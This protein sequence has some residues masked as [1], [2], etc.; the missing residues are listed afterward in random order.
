MERLRYFKYDEKY[1][2]KL[3]ISNE[4][5]DIK[6]QELNYHI[7][8]KLSLKELNK[9]SYRNWLSDIVIDVYL[10]FLLKNY[11]K[12]NCGKTNTFFIM[13]VAK[14]EYEKAK[15]WE[16]I[17]DL[18]NGKYDYFLI[19]FSC[20]QHWSLF[21]VCFREKQIRV[22]DSLGYQQKDTFEK[23]SFFLSSQGLPDFKHKPLVLNHQKNSYDCG[24]FLLFYVESLI[25]GRC[26]STINQSAVRFY[27]SVIYNDL[28][29]ILE[30]QGKSLPKVDTN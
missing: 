20:L 25:I 29:Q 21:Y 2:P 28:V 1:K 19:P 14:N 12:L 13:N 16:G 5:L 18:L 6:T 11:C 30:T 7:S 15:S 8:T 9:F 22:L 3:C 27:R 4:K 26:P 17:T 24:A 23:L 10:E